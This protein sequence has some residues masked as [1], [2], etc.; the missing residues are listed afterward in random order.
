MPHPRLTLTLA[1]LYVLAALLL[2]M[3]AAWVTRA[4]HAQTR[5]PAP[6]SHYASPTGTGST[7]TESAPC[8]LTTWITSSSLARPGATLCLM[9]GTYGDGLALTGPMSGTAEQPITVRALHDGKVVIDGQ[10]GQR[11]L[12]CLASYWTVEGLDLRNGHDSVAVLRGTGCVARR[13]VAYSTDHTLEHHLNEVIDVGGTRNLCEDCAAFGF[14]RKMIAVGARGGPGPNTIRRAFVELNGFQPTAESGHPTNPIE[15][16]YDQDNVTFENIIAHRDILAS[17]SEPEAP[18]MMFSTR[19]SGVYGAIAYLKGGETFE[20]GLLAYVIPE[21][22]SHVGSGHATSHSV[23]QDLV[24]YV[25]PSFQNVKGFYIQGGSGSTGNRGENLVAIAPTAGSGCGGG[26]WTCTH[27]KQGTTVEA[28]LGAGKSIWNEV[29]G[30]CKRYVNRVLTTS[31]LWPF[32]ISARL[33]AAMIAAGR[34]PVELTKTMEQIFGPIPAACRTGAPAGDTIPPTVQM[35]APSDGALVSGRSVAVT[36]TAADNVG[37]TGIQFY[38]DGIPKGEP[39]CCA[40]AT[41]LIDTT[42]VSN[43]QYVLQAEAVDAAGNRTM[44]SAI[45]VTVYN[46]PQPQPPGHVPLRCTG[47]VVSVP[48]PLALTCVPQQEGRR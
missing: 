23:I 19:G 28:A 18:L 25:H 39:Q 48:G 45:T 33:D 43:G 4:V 13:I 17:A 38:A 8:R 21:G 32:P 47:D 12:D 3:L 40:E 20:P 26:G 37:V 24:T 46:T 36:A 16:G 6:C 2:T 31:P 35:T 27:I 9:D 14:A 1:V 29:P 22:G 7:C 15:L 10:Y 5:A 30:I 44:S 34:P 11:P 42:T 41:R